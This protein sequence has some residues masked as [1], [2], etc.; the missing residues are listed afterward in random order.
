MTNKPVSAPAG[1]RLVLASTNPGKL[2]E[3]QELLAPTGL[4]VFAQDRFNIGPVAETGLSFV[5][6]AL[7][8]ARHAARY[9][10]LPALA[11]DSGLEVDCLGGSPGIHS[12][13]FAGEGASDAQN[14]QRLLSLLQDVPEPERSARFQCVLVLMRHPLDP[15][16]LICQGT[17]AG[18]ILFAPRGKGGFGYDPLFFVPE[19]RRSAAELTSTEKNLR[20]HRGQALAALLLALRGEVRTGERRVAT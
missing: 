11:D 9:S 10:G 16:P 6:N 3:F 8:K 1:C 15:A 13:R 19:C 2:R 14:N 20:S 18:R 5:E 4:V 7:L 17:W 12:A